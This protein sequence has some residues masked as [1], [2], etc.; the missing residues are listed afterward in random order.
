MGY[1][2][3]ERR[4]PLTGDPLTVGGP[5][6]PEDHEVDEADVLFLIIQ[7]R[8][9]NSVVAKGRGLW[10]RGQHD[11]NWEGV[12][13]VTGE[14]PDGSA[15]QLTPGMARGIALA[16]VVRPGKLFQDDALAAQE[17]AE[18][19]SGPTGPTLIFDPPQ[20]EGVTWCAN[21]LFEAAGA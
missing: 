17:A 2:R 15:G 7:G 13:S 4:I 5:F 6:D 21:F 3:F 16:V 11:D 19:G 14:K 1:G 18:A 20:V 8:G 10:Q 9:A 12:T